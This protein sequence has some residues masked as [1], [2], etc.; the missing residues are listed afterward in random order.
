MIPSTLWGVLGD[1]PEGE[2]DIDTCLQRGDFKY[3]LG[4]VVPM[5]EEEWLCVF[6]AS[7]MHD[8]ARKVADVDAL[9]VVETGEGKC[10]DQLGAHE[11]HGAAGI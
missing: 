7:S 1:P 2:E 11:R 5:L 4:E 9:L 10:F 3:F 8:L 6:L